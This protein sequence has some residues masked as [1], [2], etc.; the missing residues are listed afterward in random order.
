MKLM[1]NP[2]FSDWKS[3]VKWSVDTF[4]CKVVASRIQ[5]DL[6]IDSTTSKTDGFI[7]TRFNTGVAYFVVASK[8]GYLQQ[9]EIFNIK[10]WSKMTGYLTYHQLKNFCCLS[11]TIRI[12]EK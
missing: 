11:G 12:S 10:Y 6:R 9:Y 1:A 3:L 7:S 8:P 5:K 2:S 4:G